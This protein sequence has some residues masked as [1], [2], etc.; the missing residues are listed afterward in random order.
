MS[1]VSCAKCNKCND[2]KNVIDLERDLE[3]GNLVCKDI[4]NCEK[5]KLNNENK[6]LKS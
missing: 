2:I 1:I 5:N 6:S 3:T 4:I